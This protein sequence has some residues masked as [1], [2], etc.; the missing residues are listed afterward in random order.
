MISFKDYSPSL[1]YHAINNIPLAENV[2]RYGSMSYFDLI[3][4]M[5]KYRDE[6]NLSEEEKEILDSDIGNFGVYEKDKVVPLDLPFIEEY[7]VEE[8]KVE[9]NKPK[10]SSGPK[11]YYVYVKNEKGNVIKVNF[12]DAKGGLTTKMNDPEAR[13]SFAARHD[14]ANKKDKTKPG[15][16]AC[17]IPRYAKSLGLSGGGTFFW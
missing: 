17:R 1:K 11:K 9:L 13:K 10:R 15:Y 8:K 5:R 12:G 14:C 4:E 7:I 3:N 6:L 16:W 2:F